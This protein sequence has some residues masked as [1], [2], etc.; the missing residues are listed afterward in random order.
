MF[1]Q[2]CFCM[3]PKLRCFFTTFFLFFDYM[4]TLFASR[5]GMDFQDGPLLET[6]LVNHRLRVEFHTLDLTKVVCDISTHLKKGKPHTFFSV[7]AF[8]P[9]L[10][11]FIYPY[12]NYT[13]KDVNL[14]PSP[15]S[16][17]DFINDISK[18]KYDKL[19]II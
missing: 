12:W 17:L 10:G 19:V 18:I 1:A 9:A 5:L 15:D 2:F 11:W 13:N 16:V 6:S 8:T 7:D 4:N 3:V 14:D